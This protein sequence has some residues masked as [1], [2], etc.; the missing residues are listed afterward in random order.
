MISNELKSFN[1][2]LRFEK[3][4]GDSGQFNVNQGSVFDLMSG[5]Q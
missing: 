2:S 4:Q 3:S 1:F 5:N